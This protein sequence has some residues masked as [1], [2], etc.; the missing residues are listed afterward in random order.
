MQV[1]KDCFLLKTFLLIFPFL[2][3]MAALLG[4]TVNAFSC[5]V[6]CSQPSAK[7]QG[8]FRFA[9]MTRKCLF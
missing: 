1:D 5:V 8:M 2:P 6:S 4:Q 9:V 3:A 7:M